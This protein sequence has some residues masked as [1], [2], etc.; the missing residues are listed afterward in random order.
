MVGAPDP[1]DMLERAAPIADDRGQSRA[2]LG[3]NDH[4]NFLC[5]APIFAQ[6]D[7]YVNLLF[8]SVH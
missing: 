6:N 3:S 2:I 8:V 4:R 5:H 7:N 1:L